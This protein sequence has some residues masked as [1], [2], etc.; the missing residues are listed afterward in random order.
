MWR[1]AAD[2]SIVLWSKLVE[3]VKKRYMHYKAV[4]EKNVQHPDFVAKAK[5]VAMTREVLQTGSAY[6]SNEERAKGVGPHSP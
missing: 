5:E 2:R 4:L 6:R 3:R 1:H